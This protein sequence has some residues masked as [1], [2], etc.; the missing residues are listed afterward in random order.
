M[1]IQERINE[2]LETPDIKSLIVEWQESFLK[3]GSTS[4]QRLE[5]ILSME[6]SQ[7]SKY[8][9]PVVRSI[10]KDPEYVSTEAQEMDRILLWR[11]TF[12]VL[13]KTLNAGT[14]AKYAWL[15]ETW[16]DLHQKAKVKQTLDHV[17]DL[18]HRYITNMS[19]VSQ[20]PYETSI[21]KTSQ[22]LYYTQINDDDE[23]KSVQSEEELPDQ[24]ISMDLD[25]VRQSVWDLIDQYPRRVLF[26]EYLVSSNVVDNM[27]ASQYKN[28]YQYYQE[29]YSNPKVHVKTIEHKGVR[30]NFKIETFQGSY[31]GIETLAM[32]FGYAIPGLNLITIHHQKP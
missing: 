11:P 27:T 3:L 26:L 18:G 5:C 32:A 1:S 22:P 12:L 28:Q 23:H 13:D 2:L 30:Y 10:C 7:M 9:D 31:R 6:I 16:E 15:Y 19:R 14:I 8:S 21:P 20:R 29:Q 25:I 4:H 17:I 24:F